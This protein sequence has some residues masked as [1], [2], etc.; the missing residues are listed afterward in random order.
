MITQARLLFSL[1]KQAEKVVESQNFKGNQR[2][3]IT[4]KVSNCEFLNVL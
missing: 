1:K 3:K 4:I 2:Y